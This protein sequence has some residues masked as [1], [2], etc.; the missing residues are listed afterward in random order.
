MIAVPTGQQLNKAYK[1]TH[2]LTQPLIETFSTDSVSAVW[3]VSLIL[4]IFAVFALCESCPLIA[5]SGWL[6]FSALTLM[7]SQ[8]NLPACSSGPVGVL[9]FA[10]RGGQ[11]AACC[12]ATSKL[13]EV[14]GYLCLCDGVC[15]FGES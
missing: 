15:V 1:Q 3:L 6:P 12:S 7:E 2:A 10:E 11:R 9:H 13:H 4:A 8:L 5:M 14:S